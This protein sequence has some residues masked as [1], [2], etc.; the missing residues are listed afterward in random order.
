ML[1]KRKELALRLALLFSAT[2]ITINFGTVQA[3]T[4]LEPLTKPLIPEFT[5][6]P[7]GP[8]FDIPPIY[9]TDPD[10]GEI[11]I[12]ENG[13]HVE[14]SAVV[15]TIKN[16]PFSPSFTSTGIQATY[17]YYNI[18]IK[19]HYLPD[20][21]WNQLY[22][23]EEGFPLQSNSNYTKIAIPV[24]HVP[25]VWGRVIGTGTQIDIQVEAMIGIIHRQLNPNATGLLDMYPYVFTGETSG[26]SNTQTVNL[27][28]NTPLNPKVTPEPSPSPTQPQAETNGIEIVVI[29][30]SVIINVLLVILVAFLLRK[31]R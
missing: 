26:W 31:R 4:E 20:S 18:R 12:K 11:A 1:T 27:P 30:A 15:I 5:V 25:R 2:F 9:S 6:E 28:A 22:R 16:Q 3:L 29:I 24:E 19:E 7:I 23:A 17:F 8:S 14:Y 21:Y 13:Y 10:T